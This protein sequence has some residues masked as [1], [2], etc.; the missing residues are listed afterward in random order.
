MIH[1]QSSRGWTELVIRRKRGRED[2]SLK[3][4]NTAYRRISK[5]N[6]VENKCL[7]KEMVARDHSNLINL[8]RFLP[9]FSKDSERG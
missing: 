8:L 3:R 5:V 1:P 2:G 6:D 4:S 9:H 7:L